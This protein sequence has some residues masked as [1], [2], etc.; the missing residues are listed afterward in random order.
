[1]PALLPKVRHMDAATSLGV[2]TQ[3]HG[4]GIRSARNSGD[5]ESMLPQI[6][7]LTYAQPLRDAMAALLIGGTPVLDA[8]AVERMSTPCA[9]VLLATGRA[10]VLAGDSFKILNASDVFRAAL[11][12]LGLQPEFSKWMA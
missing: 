11:A 1:M 9:Q 6:L 4:A 10:A 7:D 3:D 12:D 5:A 8:S 2:D